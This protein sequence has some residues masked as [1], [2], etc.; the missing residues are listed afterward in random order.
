MQYKHDIDLSNQLRETKQLVCFT[1]YYVHYKSTVI[2]FE[3]YC[4]KSNILH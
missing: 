1:L 3:I 2:S 4:I